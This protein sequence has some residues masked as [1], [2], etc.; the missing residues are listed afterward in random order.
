MDVAAARITAQADGKSRKQRA[1]TGHP[2]PQQ[3]HS[4]PH[5]HS[6]ATIDVDEHRNYT[7]SNKESR[8]SDILFH[9]FRL[10]HE[11]LIEDYSCA[12]S[13]EILLHGRMV[14]NVGRTELESARPSRTFYITLWHRPFTFHIV[15][16]SM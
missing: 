7:K 14:S 1:N 6:H 12:I 15:S 5:T 3:Q 4:R 9:L 13:A 16:R 8:A 2:K 11:K 10:K